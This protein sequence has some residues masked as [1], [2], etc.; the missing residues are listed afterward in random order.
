MTEITGV[1]KRVEKVGQD[2]DLIPVWKIILTDGRAYRT[3]VGHNVGFDVKGRCN[4][5]DQ[6]T[7]VLSQN[8]I[9]E[10]TR[11]GV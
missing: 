10:Y 1:I 8:R 9:I 5:G 3:Q 4:P 11:I 7:M 6:V 2:R